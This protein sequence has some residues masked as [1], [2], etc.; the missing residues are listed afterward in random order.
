MKICVN[1]L[2]RNAVETCVIWYGRDIWEVCVFV[3]WVFRISTVDRVLD[4]GSEMG[5]RDILFITCAMQLAGTELPNDY[6]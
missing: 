5:R 1:A 4:G 3:E 2:K 6:A